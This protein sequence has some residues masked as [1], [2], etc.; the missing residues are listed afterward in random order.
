MHIL[1]VYVKSATLHCVCQLKNVT[2]SSWTYVCVCYI[3]YDT[4]N[5]HY[6]DEGVINANK[7]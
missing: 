4:G 3:F 2:P 5:N 6:Q 1:T 7:Q